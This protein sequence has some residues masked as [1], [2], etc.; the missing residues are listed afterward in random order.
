M[1]LYVHDHIS[2][3]PPI[4]ITCS[5]LHSYKENFG[6]NLACYTIMNLIHA[7]IINDLCCCM[8][9]W[10]IA[11]PLQLLWHHK[12][13]KTLILSSY[14]SNIQFIRAKLCYLRGLYKGQHR[15][16]APIIISI[17]FPYCTYSSEAQYS[18]ILRI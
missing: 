10:I 17:Y 7:H 11:T 5:D 6:E 4:A 15:S 14:T 2:S 12:I 3:Q 16:C 9:L 13:D 8:L 1:V 18:L